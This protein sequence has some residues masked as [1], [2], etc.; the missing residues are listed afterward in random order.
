MGLGQ[1]RDLRLYR[2]C[3]CPDKSLGL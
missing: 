2:R 1:V 3:A